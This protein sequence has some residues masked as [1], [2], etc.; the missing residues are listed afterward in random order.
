MIKVYSSPVGAAVHNVKNVLEAGGIECTIR[1]ESLA[2]GAGEIPLVECWAELWIV[3]DSRI[4][5]ANSIISAAAQPAGESWT[6]PACQE[7]VEAQFEQCWNCQA[8]RPSG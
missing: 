7:S 6:C 8:H 1:G 3:D 5:E 2:A 4:D